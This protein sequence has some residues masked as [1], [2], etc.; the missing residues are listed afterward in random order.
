MGNVEKQEEVTIGVE[1]VEN[2]IRKM[3]NWKARGP[4]CL[5]LHMG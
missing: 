5:S 2:G 4:G 1:D 3:V